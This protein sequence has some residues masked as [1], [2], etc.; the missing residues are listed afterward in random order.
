[1]REAL[2]RQRAQVA[3]AVDARGAVAQ[4]EEWA[5]NKPGHVTQEDWQRAVGQAGAWRDAHKA[6][7]TTLTRD[8]PE[9]T[10]AEDGMRRTLEDT[11]AREVRTHTMHER[12]ME[13]RERLER[14]RARLERSRAARNTAQPAPAHRPEGPAQRGP[15]LH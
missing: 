12:Q 5:A 1:L 11:G 13:A 4:H 9:A 8:I 7:P 10:S 14:A 2:E 6:A 3:R 15:S